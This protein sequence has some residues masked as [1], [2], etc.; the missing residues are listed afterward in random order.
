[1]QNKISFVKS[2]SPWYQ[3]WHLSYL[4]HSTGLGSVCV[5]VCCV[6]LGETLVSLCCGTEGDFCLMRRAEQRDGQHEM[7]NFMCE[8]TVCWIALLWPCDACLINP[9]VPVSVW[10]QS[11]R[12]KHIS[13]EKKFLFRRPEQ[14]MMKLDLHSLVKK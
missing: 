8:A 11:I 5:C 13:K 14:N 1:M 6:C 9:Y 12:C 3:A 2:L 4:R 10:L 7:L